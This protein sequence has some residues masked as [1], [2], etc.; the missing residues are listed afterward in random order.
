MQVE[1][2][3]F[4]AACFFIVVASIASPAQD[5]AP[6]RKDP[7][8][9]CISKI[10]NSPQEAY[11]SCALYLERSYSDDVERVDYVK[12]WMA[13]F[14]NARPQIEFLQSLTTDTHAA[15]VVYDPDMMIDLPQTSDDKGRYKIHI[16]RSFADPTEEGMLRKAEAVYPGP[17]EMIQD[18]FRSLGGRVDESAKEMA[19]IWGSP[20]ND[21]IELTKTVTARA[22]RYYYDLSLA[23]RKEPHLPTGFTAEATT[24]K[25]EAEIKHFEHY[26]HGKDAFNN[27]YV[28]D[29]TLEWGFDCG[30]L[31]GMGFTRNKLVVLDSQ[32]SVVALYL[33][34]PT[35]SEFWMS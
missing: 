7:Y 31:C 24:L 11:E 29:L 10:Q 23:A 15:W 35:N 17:S 12:N 21:R 2:R 14:G 3:S 6:A 18:L 8:S 33:D 32:G 9:I 26:S 1:A 16:A 34:A 4:S 19:P 28:A 5:G 20:G 30:G 25:Y 13:K 22:V 27:V